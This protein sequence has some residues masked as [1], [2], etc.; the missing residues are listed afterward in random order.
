MH[1]TPADVRHSYATDNTAVGNEPL[2]YNKHS[3]EAVGNGYRTPTRPGTAYNITTTPAVGTAYDGANAGYGHHNAG[4]QETGLAG[5]DEI[6]ASQYNT[7]SVH[8]HNYST[9]F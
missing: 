2:G 5:R 1:S 3:N 6:P 4:Y 7:H 9:T 8:D